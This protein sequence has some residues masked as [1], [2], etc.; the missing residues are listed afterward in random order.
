MAMRTDEFLAQHPV[1]RANIEA[2]KQRML[3]EVR[4]FKLRELRQDAGLT[5]QQVAE[6]I[7]VSQ[8]QV[9]KIERGD[10]DSAKVG[11]IRGYLEAVGGELALEF[12]SGDARVQVA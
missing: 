5:Q 4:A 8:R 3:A 12:V 10:L 7:G 11:T 1:D 6:R 2:H 9:S